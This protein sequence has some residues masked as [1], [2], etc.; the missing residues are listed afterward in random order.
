MPAAGGDQRRAALGEHVLALV[1]VAGA[2]G[3]EVGGGAAEVVAAAHREH[4]VVEVEGVA[5]DLAACAVRTS[6]PAAVAA[7]SRNE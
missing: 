2:A 3:A 6:A 4:V 5:L 1:A 7:V